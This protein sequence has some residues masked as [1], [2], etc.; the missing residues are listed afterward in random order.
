MHCRPAL[1]NLHAQ[2]DGPVAEQVECQVQLQ[3]CSTSLWTCL[4]DGRLTVEYIPNPPVGVSPFRFHPPD[5][6][7]AVK[8]PDTPLSIDWLSLIQS[9]IV[10]GLSYWKLTPLV[11]SCRPL[12]CR[13][14]YL[15]YTILCVC[16]CVR[17]T[18]SFWYF[19]SM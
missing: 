5:E 4:L 8:S 1:R 6:P 9:E 11:H 3:H 7:T 19:K 18:Y 13:R 15:H 2:A 14:P 12:A 17:V 16:V 10:A